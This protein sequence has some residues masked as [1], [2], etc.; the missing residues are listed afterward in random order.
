[1][2]TAV[3]INLKA[4][5]RNK[6]KKPETLIPSIMNAV[7]SLLMCRNQHMNRCALTNSFILKRGK[8]DKMCFNRFHSVNMCLLY[9]RV[10][11]KQEELGKDSR[12][13]LTLTYL[14]KH[15]IDARKHSDGERI[16]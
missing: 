8:A 5:V 14:V 4:K 12:N 1:M 10:V 13:A 2:V 6:I 9:Q 7:N 11:L 3:A 16:I 15:F